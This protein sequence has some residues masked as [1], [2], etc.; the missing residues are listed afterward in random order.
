MNTPQIICGD[1]NTDEKKVDNY[2]GMLT[3]LNAEDG[4]ISGIKKFIFD[5]ESNDAFRS[6]HPN[7]RLIDYILTRNSNLIQWISRRVAIIKLKWGKG[8]EYLSDHN[9][10]ETFIVFRKGDYLSKVY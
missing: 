2:K 1:F 3:I 4:V 6:T 7:P 5:D 8:T 10:L 9:G